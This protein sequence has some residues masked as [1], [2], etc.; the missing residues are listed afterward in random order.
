MR[1]FIAITAVCITISFVGCNGNSANQTEAS[2]NA[3]SS[4]Q[5]NPTNLGPNAKTPVLEPATREAVDFRE[6][7]L[8][9]R[10]RTFVVT[11]GTVSVRGTGRVVSSD[12]PEGA[13]FNGQYHE[14]NEDS[15]MTITCD[16]PISVH[17]DKFTLK[18]GKAVVSAKSDG[19]SIDVNV[20]GELDIRGHV[21]YTVVGFPVVEATGGARAHLANCGEIEAGYDSV[22][23][24]INCN[25][26]DVTYTNAEVRTENCG[27]IIV[28]GDKSKVLVVGSGKVEASEEAIPNVTYAK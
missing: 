6:T 25:T 9:N 19:G 26:V 13:E 20:R 5:A 2:T 16:G 28:K 27:T 18:I 3:S 8:K 1:N 7:V 24:A 23:T 17:G 11:G 10:T 21:I 22:I 14:S 15:E 12:H 4:T